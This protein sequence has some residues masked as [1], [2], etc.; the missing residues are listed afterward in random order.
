ME[1]VFRFLPREQVHV[2]KFDDFRKDTP[3]VVNGVFTFLGVKPLST[4][5]NREQNLI[6][7]ERKM[8]PEEREHL[9]LAYK[10]D[11]ARLEGLLG[12]DCSDWKPM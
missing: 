10:E 4:V 5:K 7:Y 2:I 6:P 1:G 11:I 3:S 9:Y 12:W 8:T